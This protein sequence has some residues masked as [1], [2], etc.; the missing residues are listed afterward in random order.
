MAI[1]GVRVC[2]PPAPDGVGIVTFTAT[3]VDPSTL[4]HR[5]DV[6]WDVQGRSGLHCAPETHV[7][8]GTQSSGA[9]RL[10]LG[11]SSTESD[12]D[13]ALEGVAAIA[14]GRVVSAPASSTR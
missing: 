7:L 10:S 11:W 2:S 9:L 14:G 1:P 4:A 13:Q 8:L 12:V 6:E 5:L 3:R